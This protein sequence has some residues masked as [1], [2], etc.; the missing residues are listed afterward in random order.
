MK[1]PSVSK[2]GNCGDSSAAFPCIEPPMSPM[3][4]TSRV[5][6]LWLYNWE[7]D[8]MSCGCFWSVKTGDLNDNCY[9]KHQF[10]GLFQRQGLYIWVKWWRMTKNWKFLAKRIQMMKLNV[11]QML[12]KN[13]RYLQKIITNLE[14]KNHDH[15]HGLN[16]SRICQ[17]PQHTR[18][19]EASD[20]TNLTLQSMRKKMKDTH[21]Q[22]A[23][24]IV[25]IYIY[26]YHI[27]FSYL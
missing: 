18:P 17:L 6:V 24:C 15:C 3:S 19:Q 9:V 25:Y 4:L 11:R 1:K 13:A 22:L 16:H 8:S 5:T 12:W 23:S 2:V 10:E 20:M 7:P 27:D 21:F 26:T 14:D